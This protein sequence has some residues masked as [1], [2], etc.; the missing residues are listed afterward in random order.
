M[1]NG[2][3]KFALFTG[4]LALLCMPMAAGAAATDVQGPTLS[5]AARLNMAAYARASIGAAEVSQ[6][7]GRG[8]EDGR[9][10]YAL[11]PSGSSL[12]EPAVPERRRVQRR[13]VGERHEPFIDPARVT[14]L[15][16]GRSR[17]V[18]SK[19]RPG[20][21]LPWFKQFQERN[22]GLGISVS[23]G[24]CFGGYF[25]CH[26][27]L[28]YIDQNSLRG[29][30]VTVGGGMQR[31][32]IDLKPLIGVPIT[33]SVGVEAFLLLY[34]AGYIDRK[35]IGPLALP[36]LGVDFKPDKH[37][38]IGVAVQVL[39][40]QAGDAKRIELYNVRMKVDF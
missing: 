19:H 30:A 2:L 18:G 33:A 32:V 25:E 3:R 28:V 26:A 1:R 40:M 14:R 34:R 27:T 22:P 13:W 12:Y 35:L 5:E 38:L 37:F 23:T 8:V 9:E 11:G 39:P 10:L 21:N 4:A 6:S 17:H 36:T 7:P 16:F 29:K 15:V 24:K 20:S 31:E